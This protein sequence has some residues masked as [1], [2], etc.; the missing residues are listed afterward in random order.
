M[1]SNTKNIKSDIATITSIG[2]QTAIIVA[3]TFSADEISYTS[4][5]GA[6]GTVQSTE[7]LN[8]LLNEATKQSYQ[9]RQLQM[10]NLQG[11]EQAQNVQNQSTCSI[12]QP[13]QNI[14]TQP[15][16][17]RQAPKQP[18]TKPH[19]KTKTASSSQQEFIQN[20]CNEK[21]KSLNEILAPYNKELSAITSDEANTIIQKLKMN[22]A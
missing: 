6:I 9:N 22:Q 2:N 13:I 20:L 11:V 3:S 8:N 17:K 21:D 15:T 10:P 4:L 1:N 12:H 14:P 5:G 19:S 7:D 18:Y 16:P